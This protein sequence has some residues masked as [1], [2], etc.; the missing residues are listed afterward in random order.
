[1]PL[2]I[3]DV[4]VEH[5]AALWPHVREYIASVL[6][7]DGSG[8]FETSDILAALLR[9]EAKLWVAWNNDR[10]TADA[11]IITEIIQY[12]RLS[13]CRI[14]IV[15]GRPGTFKSWVFAARDMIEAYARAHGCAFVSG[16]MRKGWI[17]IG[18][19]GWRESGSTY[20]KD[21]RL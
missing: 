7:R 16:A 5:V 12:P 2:P 4:P 1:M 10:Q 9:G 18:G 13:E 3:S 8:R 6:K 15:G 19:P 20:D 21:L 17:R 14:W 11:A